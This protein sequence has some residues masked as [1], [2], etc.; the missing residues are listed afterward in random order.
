M[1][2]LLPFLALLVLLTGCASEPGEMNRAL[3]LRTKLLQSSN[4]I[5]DAEITAD[6]REDLYTFGMHCTAD[7]KGEITFQVTKPDSISGITGTLSQEG[8]ALTFD[9]TALQFELLADGRLSPVSAPWVLMQALRGG[10]ITSAGTEDGQIRLSVNDSFDDDAL[11][12][13]IW[14]DEADLP[15]RA[16]ICCAGRRILTVCVENMVIE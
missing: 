5:F 11:N 8:G 16:E 14:L 3:A 10:Y 12:L 2:K 13:D 15:K 6:Y 4:C 9:S 7:E 1:K